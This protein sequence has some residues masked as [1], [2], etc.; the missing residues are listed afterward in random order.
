M[1]LVDEADF[2]DNIDLGKIGSRAI[3]A[4]LGLSTR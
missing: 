2:D 3:Q 1:Y 4:K